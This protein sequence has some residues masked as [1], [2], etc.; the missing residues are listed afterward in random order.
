M[1]DIRLLKNAEKNLMHG[2]WKDHRGP[3]P[4]EDESTEPDVI[5]DGNGDETGEAMAV[6]PP[7]LAW[8]TTCS[9]RS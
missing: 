6:E 3:P 8:R 4:P 5:F 1:E 9:F 2:M 7:G